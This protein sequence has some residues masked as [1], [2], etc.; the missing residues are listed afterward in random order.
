MVQKV[1]RRKIFL[2]SIYIQSRSR[3]QSG[4]PKV[5]KVTA[6]RSHIRY[7]IVLVYLIIMYIEISLVVSQ[8]VLFLKSGFDHL[9]RFCEFA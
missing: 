4:L 6:I 7:Y 3:L 2:V 9:H 1:I 8:T 5:S